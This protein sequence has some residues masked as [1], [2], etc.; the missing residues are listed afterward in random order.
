MSVLVTLFISDRVGGASDLE[1][2]VFVARM[3][4]RST[5]VSLILFSVCQFCMT[6]GP[7]RLV[8]CLG[9]GWISG[10]GG[11]GFLALAWRCRR[12]LAAMCRSDGCA[13][14]GCASAEL[15]GGLRVV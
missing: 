11:S 10:H 1:M 15:R 4:C 5:A 2:T 14:L 6:S 8:A 13:G 12:V 7:R 3:H 9:S